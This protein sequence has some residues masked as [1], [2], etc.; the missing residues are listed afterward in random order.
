MACDA[1]RCS[2]FKVGWVSVVEGTAGRAAGQRIGNLLAECLNGWLAEFPPRAASPAGPRAACHAQ[3]YARHARLL[4]PQGVCCVP[5]GAGG[6]CGHVSRSLPLCSLPP[7]S[8]PL[9]HTCQRRCIPLQSDTFFP[10]PPAS[11]P[12][13]VPP[14]ASLPAC[15]PASPSP[16]RPSSQ[17]ARAARCRASRRRLCPRSC[18]PSRW[19]AGGVGWWAGLWCGGSV[20]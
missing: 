14:P 17:R 15:L 20:G 2:G 4:W 12:A 5:V 6:L 18:L 16:P 11:L 7:F 13:C 3:G 10:R 19:A 9:A 8:S 1:R